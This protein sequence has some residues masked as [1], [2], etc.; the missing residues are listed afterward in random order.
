MNSNRLT[1]KIYQ[2]KWKKFKRFKS[3]SKRKTESCTRKYPKSYELI[4]LYKVQARKMSL[5]IQSAEREN[6]TTWDTLGEI[7]NSSDEK[8][9]RVCQY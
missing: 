4:F 5:Y 7:K 3:A 9:K 6:P 2:S 8:T 1:R